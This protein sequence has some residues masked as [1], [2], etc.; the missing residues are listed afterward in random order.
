LVDSTLS[1]ALESAREHLV[2]P[3]VLTT[4]LALSIILGLS[5][6][7]LTFQLLETGP[8]LAYWT[9][10]VFATYATGTFVTEFAMIVMRNRAAGPVQ[11]VLLT[12]LVNGGIA[13]TFLYYLNR[14]V[15][16]PPPYPLDDVVA[17]FGF[18]TT[19]TMAVSAVHALAMHHRAPTLAA[20]ETPREPALLARMPKDRR[21]RL[22]SIQV[23]DHYVAVTT[24]AGTAM[25]LMRLA[26]AI[27]ETDPE[28]GLQVHRSHWV[29][30]SQVTSARRTGETAVLTMID[31]REVPV[32]RGKLAEVQAVGL[33]PII[34]EAAPAGRAMAGG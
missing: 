31:G 24:T 17:L 7:F 22:V 32:S 12:G 19:V 23:Q 28:P 27:G 9:F 2:H 34:R 25:L 16:G 29:A 5:G 4:M 26:D 15:F 1:S 11:Q 33:L 10:V 20:R 8:R 3:V 30:L 14:Q 18:V 13:T 6:P 21:G